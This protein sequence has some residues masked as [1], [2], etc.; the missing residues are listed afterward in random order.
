MSILKAATVTLAICALAAPA[1]EA[2]MTWT[3]Q[4]FVNASIGVQGGSHSLATST[5]FT[6]YD[7]P[8]SLTTTQDV[9]GGA[10]FDISGGYKV[11]RNLA[12]GIGLSRVGS[13][14]DVTVDAL[15]PDPLI[16]DRLRA[17]TTGAGAAKYSEVA[18]HL[19]GTWMMPVTDK[20][21]VGFS[22]GPTIFL[23]S[24]DLPSALDPSDIS[25]PGPTIRQVTLSSVDNTTLGIHLGVDTTYLVTP[26]IGAGV[27]VRYS[28]GS[29]DLEGATDNLTVGGFQIG[30]GVRIRF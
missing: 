6:I 10:F 8:G 29:A 2:Q 30:G 14:A 25:E 19:S 24:Q 17:V 18:V 3:D 27:L 9:G 7:E 4:G 13:E 28:V 5:E 1:A 11:W 22:F 20:V 15:I 12:V 23:V 16:T 26:R 21:D